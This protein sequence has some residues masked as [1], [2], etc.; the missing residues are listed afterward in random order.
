MSYTKSIY[1]VRTCSPTLVPTCPALSTH[2]LRACAPFHCPRPLPAAT[3]SHPR[4]FHSR[5]APPCAFRP[6]LHGTPFVV[7]AAT[8]GVDAAWVSRHGVA[9]AGVATAWVLRHGCCGSACGDDSCCG[10]TCR[11][12]GVVATGESTWGVCRR[13]VCRGVAV[14]AM[15]IEARGIAATGVSRHWG[16]GGV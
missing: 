8:A 5:A 11:G 13:W 6:T 2:P 14:V 15:G 16:C 7:C 4:L 10:S 9:A 3:L 12:V 1:A